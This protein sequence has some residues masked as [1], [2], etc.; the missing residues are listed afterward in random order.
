[1]LPF[2]A[3]GRKNAPHKQP[4]LSSIAII[5]KSFKRIIGDLIIDKIMEQFSLANNIRTSFGILTLM[6]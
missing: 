6:E 4:T 5:D 2:P 1:M 3:Y